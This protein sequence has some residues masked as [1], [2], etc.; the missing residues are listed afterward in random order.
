MEAYLNSISG[1]DDA[2]VSMFISKRN[3]NREKELEIRKLCES[4]T[5]RNG[6]FYD[7]VF[8]IGQSDINW[9]T[10]LEDI[11]RDKK[12]FQDLLD[13]VCKWGTKHITMLRFIDLSFMVYGLHRAGQDD[14]DAHAYRYNN[15]I[16]RSSTRL[17]KFKDEMS[18]F[19][20]DKI[21]T[22]D[23]A[24]SIIEIKTPDSIVKD[25]VTYVKTVNGYVREDLKDNKDA[26]RGLYMLSIPSNF[27]FR[28]NL[29]EFAHVYKERNI[30]GSANP[31][32]KELCEM[33]ADLLE[34]AHSQFNRTLLEAIEN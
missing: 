9:G 30:H 33:C 27:I 25:G 23:Q 29:V 3:I 4:F 26:L 20:Q 34:K 21:I 18:D 32:V 31:E 8:P 5:S 14:W 2:I 24:L 13:K 12:E 6:S 1:I 10:V 16:I 28:V 7:R 17:A 19:Y 11:K 22:T 15:R